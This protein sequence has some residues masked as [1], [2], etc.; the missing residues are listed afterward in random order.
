[1]KTTYD[2]NLFYDDELDEYVYQGEKFCYVLG[3]FEPEPT[4]SEIILLGDI[5]DCDL[6]KI[7]SAN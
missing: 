2:E 6:E 7:D 3:G 4:I 1:M 5:V